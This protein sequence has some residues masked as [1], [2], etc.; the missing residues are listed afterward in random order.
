MNTSPR[1]NRYLASLGFC[2]RRDADALISAGRVTINGKTA[3][4]ADHVTAGDSVRVDA[5]AVE[6]LK[7]SYVYLAFNKP[8]DVVTHSP[9]TGQK[10]IEDFVPGDLPVAPIGRLDRQSRGLIILTNDGRVT[11]KLLDPTAGHE[12]EYE[13]TVQPRV[14]KWFLDRMSTGVD[15][16]GYVTKPCIVKKISSKKIRII[17]SEGKNRQIRKMCGALG[18]EVLDLQRIRIMNIGLGGLP[19]GKFRQIQDRELAEFMTNL[20]LTA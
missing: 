8:A 3:Q 6:R 5:K 17:L 7:K 14:S 13:V 15:I 11:G 9:Q 4:L 19:E 2:S 18:Y 10:S 1:I 16:G 20:G 12:K